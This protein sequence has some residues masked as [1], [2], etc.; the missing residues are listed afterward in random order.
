MANYFP[1]VNGFRFVIV[2]MGP[3]RDAHPAEGDM[4]AAI[5]EMREKLPGLVDVMEPKSPG[6]HRSDTVDFGV[7]LSGQA[8]LELDD[9]MEVRLETGDSVILNGIR[10]AWHNR[11]ARSCALVLAAVGAQRT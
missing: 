6:M 5:E 1:P 3:D 9:G 8:W 11:S 2:E 7:V 10:H 4:Q